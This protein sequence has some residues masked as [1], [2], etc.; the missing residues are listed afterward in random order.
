MSHLSRIF[1]SVAICFAI[2]GTAATSLAQTSVVTHTIERGETLESIAEKYGVTKEA[3]LQANAAATQFTY[4]GMELQIPVSQAHPTENE[5]TTQNANDQVLLHPLADNTKSDLPAPSNDASPSLTPSNFSQFRITY[6]GDFDHF[7]K[8]VY[9]IGG[10][11]FSDSGWGGNF[12]YGTN[13]GL[14]DSS[15]SIMF[16]EI[17][18]SYAYTYNN[19][20]LSADLNFIGVFGSTEEL[21]TKTSKESTIGNHYFPPKEYMTTELKHKFAWGITFTP[22]IGV[23]IKRVIPFIG[24][25]FVG[26]RASNE[27]G[28]TVFDI[29]VG[30][31]IGIGITF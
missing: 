29:N 20:F 17:G 23:K 3:I 7:D 9:A 14:V 30:L 19:I 11:Y 16:F 24:P 26:Q 12:T 31:T 28:E 21:V 8:G 2:L 13:L 18:P 25:R 1:R 6:S 22:R 4:V 27:K 15:I 5:A 10:S